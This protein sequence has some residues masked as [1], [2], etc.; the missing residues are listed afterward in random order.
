MKVVGRT[1][2]TALLRG[3]LTKESPEF[4]AI[5]GRRRIGKTFL[6][7]QTYSEHIV[8]ECSGLHQ[9]TFSQQ[10][11][12]FWLTLH[13][14][15][16][17]RKPEL[18]PKSW[19]QAFAQLK[20]YLTNLPGK[21]KKVVFFDEISWFETPKAGFLAALDNFWNQFCTKRSDII[22]VICGSAASWII[23]KV[24]NDRGG[25][26]NRITKKIQLAPF[27]LQETKLFLETNQVFLT[28]KDLAQIYMVVGGIPFYLRD[29]SPGQS[30][31][32]ILDELFIGPQATLAN[33]FHNLYAA[34]F[35]NNQL[36]EEIV[37]IL[38]G[39]NMGMTRAELLQGLKLTSGGGLSIALEELIA[40]GF[41]QKIYPINKTKAESLFRLMDEYTLFYFKFLH[42]QRNNSS[43]QQLVSKPSYKIWSGY[44]FENLCIRHVNQIKTALGIRGIVS[45]NYSWY[46]KGS[47]KEAGGQIDFIIDRDDN[48]INLFE[49]KFYNT[50]FEFTQ[51]DV[52]LLQKKEMS[53]KKNTRTKKNVFWTLLTVFGAKPNTHF[54]S[55]ITNQIT[56]EDLFK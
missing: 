49:I 14:F 28:P 19:L 32:Q 7:R 15:D 38:A 48:C 23:H 35:K 21:E 44:A 24:I 39:K 1:S 54:L 37:Q 46:S 31:P 20:S 45:N 22:L 40:C 51:N 55:I 13:E 3:L 6:I 30:V 53:F 5:Y 36:H 56:L 41:V 27:S 16:P 42:N 11:E 52:A 34:L 2:E 29:I 25:L 47:A 17:T 50:E 43:W 10:L 26:H 12:N 4:V 33:E 9:K 18:P 8:F